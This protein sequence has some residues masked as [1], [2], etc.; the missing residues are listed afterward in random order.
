[1]V[2]I[3]GNQPDGAKRIGAKQNLWRKIASR[4]RQRVGGG[5]TFDIPYAACRLCVPVCVL[6]SRAVA[7]KYS[8][9]ELVGAI[10]KFEPPR[11][12]AH[13]RPTQRSGIATMVSAHGVPSEASIR[14]IAVLVYATPGFCPNFSGA[15]PTR[16]AGLNIGRVVRPLRASPLPLKICAIPW[17]FSWSQSRMA[18]PGWSVWQPPQRR[19]AR[20]C[21]MERSA[22]RKRCTLNWPFLKTGVLEQYGYGAVKTDMAIAESYAPIW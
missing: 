5:P 21:V 20:C 3:N 16:I 2:A 14:L 13:S 10:L 18:L 22:N 4:R 7:A 19:P 15:T 9:P 8:S 17:V 11:C 1:M 12:W 6:P